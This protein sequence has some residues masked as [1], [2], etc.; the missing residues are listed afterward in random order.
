MHFVLLS[1]FSWGVALLTWSWTLVSG[2]VIFTTIRWQKDQ[3]KPWVNLRGSENRKNHSLTFQAVF[4]LEDCKLSPISTWYWRLE[5]G[6]QGVS[7]TG[8][9]WGLWGKDLFWIFLLGLEIAVFS[10]CSFTLFSCYVCLS[11]HPNFSF[12][13][14]TT[15]I[16][17]QCPL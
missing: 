7:R 13:K 1:A 6:N 17:D 12:F 4:P 10:L 9:F 11:L 15:I 14:R 5:V 16:L 2:P 8:S 3:W